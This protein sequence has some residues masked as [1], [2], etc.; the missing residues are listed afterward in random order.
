MHIAWENV[1][2]MLAEQYAAQTF[3]INAR[4]DTPAP[5]DGDA[6]LD[7]GGAAAGTGDVNLFDD[8]GFTGIHAIERI[9]FPNPD[10]AAVELAAGYKPAALP[11]TAQEATDFKTKLV[12]KLI[13][14]VK[15][16]TETY[17]AAPVVLSYAFGRVSSFMKQLQTILQ[18]SVDKKERSRYSKQTILDLR[19]ALDGTQLSY[20]IFQPWLLQGRVAP[21]DPSK[22]GAAHDKPIQAGFGDMIFAFNAPQG[23]AMPTP[24]SP[25][26][27]AAPTT[28][29][30]P[31]GK[32]WLAQAANNSRDNKS[33]VINELD[34]VAGILGLK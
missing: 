34:V 18:E 24:P 2:P 4:I 28:K 3:A 21:Q 16:L 1:E 15:A 23:D 13:N 31:F 19:A 14:D 5:S 22:H 10:F 33:S 27:P 6:G 32:L 7:G 8:T 12:Q 17:N 29:D 25:W 26:D 9:L 30:N 20:K 11:L